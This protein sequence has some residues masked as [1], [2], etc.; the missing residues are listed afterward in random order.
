M[1]LTDLYGDFIDYDIAKNLNK[2]IYK[3]Y[4]KHCVTNGTQ[5]SKDLVDYLF[6]A[7]R[8]F[9]I[10]LGDKETL[11]KKMEKVVYVFNKDK[12]KVLGAFDSGM[13]ASRHF[14]PSKYTINDRIKDEKLAFDGNYY[15]RGPEAVK[16]VLSLG[17]GTAGNYKLD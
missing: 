10:E 8:Y 11:H 3:N 16:L 1:V 6:L 4:N 15:L 9:C 13:D 5:C 7:D 12:T 2:I 14:R 17:H